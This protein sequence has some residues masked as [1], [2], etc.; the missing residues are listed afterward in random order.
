MV[1]IYHNPACSKSREALDAL[2]QRAQS[3]GE[4]VEV[5]EYLKTPLSAD[6]LRALQQ[7]LGVPAQEMLR[8]NEDAYKSLG[9][10]D[11]NSDDRAL[12]AIVATNPALL[13]RPIIVRGD[14]AV[15]GRPA[16]RINELY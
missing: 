3:S 2:Q 11:A 16:E 6:D 1:T 12:L 7:K 15:I 4:Q 9:L 13:Q 8:P 14:K 10:A 5:V